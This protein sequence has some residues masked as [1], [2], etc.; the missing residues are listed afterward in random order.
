MINNKKIYIIAAVD[1]KNGLGK[2]G[3]LAWRL[4]KEMR[5]FTKTSTETLDPK[6]QN[7]VIM[8]QTT[9]ESIP[10]KFRPLP[11]RKNIVLSL[12]ES[13]STDGAEVFNSIDASLESI[14]NSIET[15]FIIGGASIYRQTITHPL[16][17]GVYL[18]RIEHDF[19]CDVFFPEIP[20]NYRIKQKIG[21]E[22]EKGINFTFYL[23]RKEL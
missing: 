22:T 11:G 12:D 15:I 16:I 17:D 9:W 23:Y 13:Y 10:E 18:T 7:C 14:D 20:E 2:N 8:G 6:K 21:S 3:D 19:Q 4:K 1:Q 5:H